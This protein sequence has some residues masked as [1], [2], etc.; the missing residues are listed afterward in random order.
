MGI[1]PD[2]RPL[3]ELHGLIRRRVPVRR[4]QDPAHRCPD[5]AYERDL[6]TP[7]RDPA[8]RASGPRPDPWRA[9][10]HAVL[11]ECQAHYNTARP[12][13]GIAQHV[14]D[15]ERDGPRVTVTDTDTQQVRRKP[16]LNGLINEYAHAA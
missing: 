10:P 14:P 15:D 12:H 13:Q 4:Y 8:P 6:R 9:A 11:A 7:G 16:I 2:S 5:A 1:P 3:V